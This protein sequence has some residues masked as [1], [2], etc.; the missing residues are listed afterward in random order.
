MAVNYASNDWSLW[1]EWG[2]QTDHNHPL[3]SLQLNNTQVSCVWIVNWVHI[4]YITLSCLQHQNHKMP[5]VTQRTPRLKSMLM[6]GPSWDI[7][8][9]FVSVRS[10]RSFY[11]LSVSKLRVILCAFDPALS[12]TG[13]FCFTMSTVSCL[14]LKHLP[15]IFPKDS[16]LIVVNATCHLN[17]SYESNCLNGL[18]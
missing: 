13:T 5:L 7:Y 4:N 11:L 1:L 2:K 3:F 15:N 16:V 18:S 6:K 12:S 10:M 9:A 8:N 17:R 14:V